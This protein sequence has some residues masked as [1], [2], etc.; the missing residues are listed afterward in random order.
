M[1]NLNPN[2]VDVVDVNDSHVLFIRN[3]R[4]FSQ[5]LCYNQHSQQVVAIKN[6]DAK[7]LVLSHIH[8]YGL[9]APYEH[10]K[11]SCLDTP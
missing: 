9:K 10:V 6:N 2:G 4:A 7:V 3:Q 5:I 1:L 8:Y 11:T